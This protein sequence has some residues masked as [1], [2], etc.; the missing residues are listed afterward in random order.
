MFIKKLLYPRTIDAFLDQLE[1]KI[2]ALNHS[3]PTSYYDTMFGVIREEYEAWVEL[4]TLPKIKKTRQTVRFVNVC[5]KTN[6]RNGERLFFRLPVVGGTK[7]DKPEAKIRNYYCRGYTEEKMNNLKNNSPLQFGYE[8]TPF[9]ASRM[10]HAHR[11]YDAA[12][13]ALVRPNT[14]L[15]RKIDRLRMW[16]SHLPWSNHNNLLKLPRGIL[17]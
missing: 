12:G 13:F 8:E 11:F 9:H 1:E 4:R 17:K 10:L 14:G 7:L 3:K 15:Q 5:I 2:V 6:N 16:G